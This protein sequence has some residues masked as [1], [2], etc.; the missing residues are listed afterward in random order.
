MCL[1]AFGGFGAGLSITRIAGRDRRQRFPQKTANAR[2]AAP[3]SCWSG[4][5]VF[6]RESPKKVGLLFRLDETHRGE[7]RDVFELVEL[8]R[9]A[10]AVGLRVRADD[11]GAAR[12]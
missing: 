1:V 7:R 8:N 10:N 3:N 9:R 2:C 11:L 4:R 6:G 12:R 5:V